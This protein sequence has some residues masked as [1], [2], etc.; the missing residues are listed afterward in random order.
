MPAVS[1]AEQS[2]VLARG[3]NAAAPISAAA[4]V[5]AAVGGPLAVIGAARRQRKI[6]GAL[7]IEG[8]SVPVVPRRQGVDHDL[9]LAS[10]TDAHPIKNLQVVAQQTGRIDVR[11]AR[12]SRRMPPSET[13]IPESKEIR[14]APRRPVKNH[15]QRAAVGDRHAAANL[16]RDAAR[17]IADDEGI[18]CAAQIQSVN[19]TI[20]INRVDEAR[21]VDVKGPAST[22]NLA[23]R[24]SA[25]LKTAPVSVQPLR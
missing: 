4:P 21:D 10:R 20:F 24:R 11:A 25:A 2:R 5:A 15:L 3:H 16:D 8:G 18:V 19:G 1:A 22:G 7:R 12:L 6:N 13:G 17:I 9:E 23:P 14:R